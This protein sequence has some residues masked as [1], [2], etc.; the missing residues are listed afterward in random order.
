LSLLSAARIRRVT[1]AFTLLATA[2]CADRMAG[3]SANSDG[4]QMRITAS[5]AAAA[6]IATLV[7]TVTAP[8]I[9]VPLVYNLSVVNGTATGTIKMPPGAARTISVKALDTDGNV[10]SEGS[11]TVA[12]VSAGNG[13][14]PVSIPM[15]SRAGHVDVTVQLGAV[16]VVVQ[17]GTAALQAGQTTQLTAVVTAANGEVLTVTPDWATADPSIATVSASGLLKGVRTGSTTIVATYAGVAGIKVVTVQGGIPA[18]F[19]YTVPF[20]SSFQMFGGLSVAMRVF[21]SSASTIDRI[22]FIAKTAGGRTVRLALYS[23]NSNAPGQLL[24]SATALPA[25]VGVNEAPIPATVLQA[26]VYWIMLLSDGAVN[27]SSG[28]AL[29]AE[30]STSAT[31]E[32]YWAA[33]LSF[34]SPFPSTYSGGSTFTGGAANLYLAGFQ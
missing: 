16:S 15:V 28:L 2:A 19:G 31:S 21:V 27:Q 3:P 4:A 22:G 12:Q 1:A 32:L 9:T 5:V 30:P 13:N 26:G 8:D 25:S 17:G 29:G 23:N 20:G 14:P 18:S 7:V 24:A 34:S 6:D 33:P 11:K 10:T